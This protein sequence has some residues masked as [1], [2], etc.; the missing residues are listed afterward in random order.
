MGA[1]LQKACQLL[2]LVL[3]QRR[4]Y[5]HVWVVSKEKHF[6]QYLSIGIAMNLVNKSLVGILTILFFAGC[7]TVALTGRSQL[8][9][10][11]DDDIIS[12][13]NKNYVS[14][15]GAANEKGAI[16]RPSESPAAAAI[17]DMVNRVT[18]RILIASGLT[19]KRNWEVVVIKSDTPNAMVLPNGKIIIFLGIIKVAKNEAGLAA[20]L[21]HEIAHVSSRHS[22][23]RISQAILADALL[24]TVGTIAA[25]KSERNQ[26]V[27][28]AALGLGLQYGILM[29]FSRTHESEADRIG[30]IYMA[31]AGYD[32]T[33][34]IAVWE[35]MERVSGKSKFEFL[36]THPANDVRKKQL[37]EWLPTAQ[38]FFVDRNRPLPTTLVDFPTPAPKAQF[39]IALQPEI[40]ED[41]WYKFKK[42]DTGKEIT[43][44]FNKLY[45]CDFGKCIDIVT[46]KGAMK[47]TSDYRL[48]QFSSEGGKSLNFSPPW[49]QIRFPVTVGDIW[50]ELITIENSGKKMKWRIQTRVVS[51]SPIDVPA[52]KFMAYKTE[53]SAGGKLIYEGWYVPETRGF[54]KSIYS[55]GKGN[56]SFSTVMS[57]YQKSTDP[58]GE[59]SRAESSKY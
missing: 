7:A 10:V 26:P 36:S 38:V 49:Q 28:S 19:N 22:A 17:I 41:Y 32:P 53:T 42:D 54:V 57:D 50:D 27:I 5:L 8:N 24:T 47:I 4:Q 37:T 2:R 34:A 23:E 33:E 35:R 3:L 9:I 12:S 48:V 25:I 51:Y 52:G 44:K 20:I 14:L 13:A 59:I 21:G 6:E 1:S 45:S 40:K 58:S 31:K 56:V 39:P 30:Q 11:S 43:L 55:D 29:P 15:I 16:L 46:D 18:Q